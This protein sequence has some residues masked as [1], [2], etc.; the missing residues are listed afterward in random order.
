MRLFFKRLQ[1]SPFQPLKFI[2][3]YRLN[4]NVNNIL[5]ERTKSII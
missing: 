5:L 2:D 3:V 1:L 4:I